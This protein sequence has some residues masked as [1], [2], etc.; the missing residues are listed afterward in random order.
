MAIPTELT[1][2]QQLF[3]CLMARHIWV[4]RV[5]PESVVEGLN[6]W[7]CGT[8]A[9]FGGHLATWSEFQEIME[10]FPGGSGEP[11]IGGI[12]I[13][14]TM[15]NPDDFLFGDARMFNPRGA[16]DSDY[17]HPEASDWEIVIHRLDHRINELL[18]A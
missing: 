9:C 12:G 10:V 17:F 1:P 18:S 5:K 11:R 15:T 3:N 6:A 4:E 14:I 16:H 7:T 8:H 13:G 2:D